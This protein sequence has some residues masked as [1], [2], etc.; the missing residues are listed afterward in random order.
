[1]ICGIKDIKPLEKSESVCAQL[2]IGYNETKQKIEIPVAIMAYCTAAVVN[3]ISSQ[4]CTILI[5][6][7][8]S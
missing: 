3:A 4:F 6:D 8:Y 5:K 2:K 1:M 7:I